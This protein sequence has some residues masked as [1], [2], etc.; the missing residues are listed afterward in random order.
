MRTNLTKGLHAAQEKTKRSQHVHSGW[1]APA[2]RR[3]SNPT[4]SEEHEHA[5]EEAVRRPA[6]KAK[7]KEQPAEV[8]LPPLPTSGAIGPIGIGEDS[9][10]PFPARKSL[11]MMPPT[12]LAEPTGQII[13]NKTVATAILSI[14]F[15][16][17]AVFALLVATAI[18]T[19]DVAS[20]I[21]IS[22]RNITGRC[23]E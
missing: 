13:Q 12:P 5:G 22:F 1:L 15:R 6:S 14:S 9:M 3:R 11:R 2:V 21:F 17:E 10:K 4:A 20:A 8:V 16:G 7:Q 23:V 18:F 19:L